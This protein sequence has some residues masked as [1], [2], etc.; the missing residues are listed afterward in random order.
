MS[1]AEPWYETLHIQSA[2]FLIKV[3]PKTNCLFR[4]FRGKELSLAKE[5]SCITVKV[6]IKKWRLFLF[7]LVDANFLAWVYGKCY[8]FLKIL[9]TIFLPSHTLVLE[10]MTLF[11]VQFR[12]GNNLSWERCVILG[13]IVNHIPGLPWRFRIEGRNR[14]V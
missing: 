1:L 2:I 9:I 10:N 5:Q 3:Q 13:L 7:V 6:G 14:L 11:S 8:A 4:T 12:K